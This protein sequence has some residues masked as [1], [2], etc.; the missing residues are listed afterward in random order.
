MIGRE[1]ETQWEIE[2][3]N[4]FPVYYSEWKKVPQS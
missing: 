2:K 1:K 3:G 4:L